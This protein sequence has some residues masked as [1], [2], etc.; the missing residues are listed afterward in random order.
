MNAL[1]MDVPLTLQPLFER[2]G[3][4]FGNRSIVWRRPDR[5][6]AR[7][8]YRQFH[9]RTQQLAN[10]LSRL[11][12][13]PG[14]RVATLAWNHG[15]HLEAYFAVPLAGF[16][17][18]TVNPRLSPQDL[19]F[20]MNDA[21]DR[22]LIVDEAL[23]P[24]LEKFRSQIDVRHIIV[25]SDGGP[26]PEGMVDYERLIAGEEALFTPDPIDERQA[27]GLCYTSGTTGRPKGVLYSHRSLVLHSLVSSMRDMF[28]LGQRDVVMPVVPMFH[29]N[30]W[31]SRGRTSI[32]RAC[33]I[34]RSPSA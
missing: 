1:M 18:H 28:G 23:L 24:V 5:S 22:V 34:S 13:A 6:V 25:W 32:P 20:I 19:A 31:C 33:W 8:S 3:R 16:V 9:A 17:L 2:A 27:A 15:R 10:A 29:V 7:H 14:D 30:A 26:I 4:L 12:L 11:G 21:S